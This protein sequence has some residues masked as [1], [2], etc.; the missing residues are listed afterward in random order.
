MILFIF[1]FHPERISTEKLMIDEK[2][3]Q[4]VKREGQTFLTRSTFFSEKF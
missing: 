4:E 3:E 2:D 1:Q